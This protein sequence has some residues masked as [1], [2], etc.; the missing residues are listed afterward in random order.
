VKTLLDLEMI[1]KDEQGNYHQVDNVLFPGDVPSFAYKKARRDMIMLSLDAAEN[2]SPEK[3]YFY[4][5][6]LSLND[7]SFERLMEL[8]INFGKE[9]ETVFITEDSPANKVYQFNMQFFP[10]S[11]NT[12]QQKDIDDRELVIAQTIT[13]S[14]PENNILTS[15]KL[16]V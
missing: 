10:V 1:T 11:K 5:C 15:E 9:F 2:L 12:V 3:R 7:A 8:M 6:T 4:N 14:V 16:N 13:G